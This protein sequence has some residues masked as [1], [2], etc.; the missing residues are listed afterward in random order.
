MIPA[1]EDENNNTYKLLGLLKLIRLLRLGRIVRYLK[2]KQ[3]FKL[4][5][6]LI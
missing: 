2:F 4:G 1:S 6:R 5:I 3:G